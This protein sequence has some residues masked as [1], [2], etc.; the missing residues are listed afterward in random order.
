MAT[1]ARQASAAPALTWFDTAIY[2]LGDFTVYAGKVIGWSLRGPRHGTLLPVCN[3][4]GVQSVPV[5]AITGFFIG[6]VLAVQSFAQF[7]SIGMATRL[8]QVV[9]ISVVRELG[10]VLAAVMLAGRVGGAMAAELATMR[11]TDQIDALACLGANPIHHLAVP[12]FIACVMLIPL[13]TIIANFM[14][15]MGG[16]LISIQVFHV[17]GHNYWQNARGVITL[18]DLSTGL[19]KPMCFGAAIAIIAC[20][21]GFKSEGGA[22]GVGKAATASFVASFIVILVVDFFLGL[23]LNNLYDFFWP[24]GTARIG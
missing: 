17:D 2:E 14:G 23:L 19:I 1:A 10:P 15:V 11:I 22:E 3:E 7:N 13:L 21:R 9:N 6:M 8:G 4:I 24:A 12:R 18:W 20:H 16:A 5:V